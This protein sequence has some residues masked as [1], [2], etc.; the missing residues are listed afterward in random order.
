[1][2][3]NDRDERIQSRT[4]QLLKPSTFQNPVQTATLL[5]IQPLEEQTL[6]GRNR[7]HEE[8][9]H[10]PF[11][12]AEWTA[13]TEADP[14]WQAARAAVRDKQRKFP[15]LVRYKVSIAECEISSDDKLLFRKRLW[16]PEHEPLRT[17][18]I[19]TAHTHPITRHPG[20]TETYT[21]LART[22][23]WP[24]MSTD[25]KRYVRNCDT[26]GRTKA[27]REQKQGLLR[28]LPIPERP[29]QE[30]SI[31]FITHLPPSQDCTNI[32]VVTD[33]LT[34]GVVVEGLK[35]ITAE[36]LAWFFVRS[37]YRYHGLPRAIVSDRGSQFVSDLWKRIC[38][39]LGIQRRLST[40]FHPQTDGA[41]ERMN[42]NLEVL[43][44][45]YTTYS[46]DNWVKLLPVLELTQNGRTASAT[47]L[48]PFFLSHGYHLSPFPD[49]IDPRDLQ[50]SQARTPIQK[51]EAIV[52]TL[53]QATEWAQ[54][55]MAL[56]QQ[57][58][59]QQ[60]NRHRQPAPQYQVGDK[61]W[62]NLRNVRTDR[63]SRKL[64]WKN[65][66]Y[67]VTK[68]VSPHAVQLNLPPGIHPVFH[69]DLLRLAASDPLPSQASDDA[70]PPAILTEDGEEEW[71]VERITGERTKRVGRRLQ[72]ELQV[73]WKGY[74]RPSWEPL[75]ALEDTVAYDNWLQQ[76]Q[77]Q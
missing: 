36:A 16:V 8:E 67:T 9:E 7:T 72:Q 33:R 34:K 39:L 47:G 10:E 68:V 69:V 53:Q 62:L 60:A 11:E 57:T 13:A 19:E 31:D 32:V 20:R 29:W 23:F 41:T 51:G 42:D 22:Y 44:R 45:T 63:P 3:T 75:E 28:P 6:E 52:R 14:I 25:V 43:L 1:L 38:Q 77:Q 74:V 61:V 76:K 30:L 65:A 73:Y 4:F 54:A 18:L 24:D 37:V 35:E 5:P 26:C 58:A 46:Q 40:A 66:K 59:E 70:Q 64:D 55:S 21:I 50:E 48:S 15:T 17:K 12:E 2:P 56:A 49:N 27:W 71:T